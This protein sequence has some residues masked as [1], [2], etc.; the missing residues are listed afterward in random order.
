[1]V[2]R[3]ARMYLDVSCVYPVL[4]SFSIRAPAGYY[5]LLQEHPLT[6]LLR[7]RYPKISN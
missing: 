5:T 2:G 6:L 7:Q 1:M 3:Q 4:I